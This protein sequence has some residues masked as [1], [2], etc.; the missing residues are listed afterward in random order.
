MSR[1]RWFA[2][3]TASALV[4]G[5]WVVMNTEL[6][7]TKGFLAQEVV[8]EP[9]YKPPVG[10]E[11]VLVFV[12]APECVANHTEGFAEAVH[13]AKLRLQRRAQEE[14]FAFSAVGVSVNWDI[15]AGV[16]YLLEGKWEGE[17]DLLFGDWDEIVVGRNWGN[18]AAVKYML[19]L[20]PGCPEI[21]E[22]FQGIPQLY[23]VSRNAEDWR[24]SGQ[25]IFGEERLLL[26]K[27]GGDAIMEWVAA[28]APIQLDAGAAK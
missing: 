3:V 2:V 10:E 16:K 13:Q 19:E 18:S 22:V 23:V 5:G 6:L 25:F 12:S 27:C 11:V 20:A 21:P 1:Q 17:E 15:T 7:G 9:S 4:A 26:H 28:G 24:A 8:Y 14:D